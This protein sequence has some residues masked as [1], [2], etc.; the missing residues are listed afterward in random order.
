ML[1]LLEALAS[2]LVIFLSPLL[3]RML[4][5]AADFLPECCWFSISF[6]ML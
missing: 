5:V 2:P 3:K 1:L 6:Q 4:L